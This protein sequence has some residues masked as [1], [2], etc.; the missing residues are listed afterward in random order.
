VELDEQITLLF[1]VNASAVERAKA[2]LGWRVFVTNA[3]LEQLSLSGAVLLYR[4]EYRIEHGFA[5]L[6]GH[7]LS[8]APVYVQEEERVKGL[9]R[10]LAL[11]LRILTLLEF[12][13]RR[14]L[15]EDPQ[16]LLGLYAGNPKRATL[17]PTAER[18][19]E[20]FKDITLLILPQ[21]GPP[22]RHM[23]PLT[24]LQKRIL[25]L[26]GTPTQVYT[27]LLDDSLLPAQNMSEP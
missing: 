24:P 14:R 3:S 5:R 16:P 8:L 10:L 27:R 9:I 4:E 11:G 6:K 18:L 15:A 13:V 17:T 23:T 20:A 7:P 21:L 22:G 12:V 26:S 19:L 1:A 25:E 2:L